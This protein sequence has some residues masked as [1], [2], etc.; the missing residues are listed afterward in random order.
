MEKLETIVKAMDDKFGENIVAIDMKLASPIFDTFVICSAS[1]E[2]TM[3]AIRDNVED[4][5]AKIQVYPKSIE[6]LKDS[7]WILMDYGDII[8][9]IFETEERK[10][11][12]IEKLWADMPFI[13]I[14]DYYGL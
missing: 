10:A 2:R 7:K 4:E 13:D 1:N 9:H 3:N 14:E 12:N 6:G 11:Y 5:L 8:I